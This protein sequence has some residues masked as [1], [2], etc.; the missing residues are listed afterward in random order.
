[1]DLIRVFT[2]FPDDEACVEHLE[3]VRW[4]DTPTCPHCQT[5]EVGRR[6][7]ERRIPRWN[8]YKCHASFSVLSGTIF[9]KTRLPL[10]KWFLAISLMLNAKK[11]P[12]SHQLAR[13]LDM[14]QKSAWRLAMQIRAA[15][16]DE[17]ELMTRIVEADE[18]FTGGKPRKRKR[19]SDDDE[20]KAPRSG[21][22]RKRPSTSVVERGTKVATKPSPCVRGKD[23]QA[24]IER[25]VD[26]VTSFLMS[27]QWQAHRRV[28][29]TMR[30]AVVDLP[31]C[32]V[33]G[34]IH[35]NRIE[36]SWALARR[37][38]MGG[39]HYSRR[40]PAVYIVES[41]LKYIIRNTADPFGV[42]IRDAVAVA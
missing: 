32:Y 3:R 38:W 24:V 25:N 15:T 29:R 4:D 36:S 14:N 21:G 12:T 42:F 7:D 11:S 20:P 9:H 13:D 40:H 37:T 19:H 5:T 23:L 18:A 39:H 6:N 35:S 16:L 30:H 41:W 26:K 33:D 8:C 22:T 31:T 27:D 17:R 28:G 34:M 2:R 1:M 10:P